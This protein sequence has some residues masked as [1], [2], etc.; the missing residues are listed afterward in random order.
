MSTYGTRDATQFP[1]PTVEKGAKFYTLVDSTTKEITLKKISSGNILGRTDLD[2]T[3]GTVPTS[4][5]NAGKFIQNPNLGLTAD[6]KA[7]LQNPQTLKTVKDKGTETVSKAIQKSG[8]TPEEAQTTANKLLSP[9]KATN[10]TAEN[11]STTGTGATS[12]DVNKEFKAGDKQGTRTKYEDLVYPLDLAASH[13]DIVKFS[14]LKYVPSLSEAGQQKDGISTAGRIVTLKD[15]KPVVKGSNPIGTI[16]LPIP[17][18]ISD[19]NSARWQDEGLNELL[20]TVAVGAKR[21]FEAGTEAAAGTIEKKGEELKSNPEALKQTVSGLLLNEA[22]GKN[23]AARAYGAVNNN[24][25]EVLFSGP[26]LRSF[27]FT[28]MF[29]PRSEP[30]A[31][32]VRKIIRAFKQSMSV[33]RSANSLLLKAPHTFAISYLTP[34]DKGQMK[35]HPYLNKFKECALTNCNIDYTPDGTY[36]TYGGAEK[37]M[38]SYRMSLT[39]AELEPIFD[40]EYGDDGDAFVGY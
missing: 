24:N 35:I 5:A 2:T 19:G 15:G 16:T 37:S 39:F 27:S 30:E 25:L 9:N 7:A 4:G 20:E 40:D 10:P 38:T 11:P 26:G 6:Q 18:G 28:F 22:T 13:Q 33:K 31:I 21:L 14:I 23:I 32:R 8:K 29:Y 36:M 34:G 17:S 12:G 3:V 1:L